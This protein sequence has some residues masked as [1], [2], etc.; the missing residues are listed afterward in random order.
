MT[1][2]ESI[3]DQFAQLVN[4]PEDQIDLVDAALLI[5]RTAYPDMK[6]SHYTGLLDAWGRQLRKQTGPDA[7]TGD[8]LREL[9]RIMFEQEGFKGDSDNYYDPQNSFLNRVLE[10]KK[11]IPITLALVYSEVAR[12]AGFSVYG[13]ALPGHFIVGLFH[14]TGTLYI[15]PFNQGEVLA[16]SECRKMIEV[17][18]GPEAASDASWR[19]PANKK[20]IIKR[21]LRNLKA[22]F[23]HS[24]RDMQILEMIQWIL[25]VDPDAPSELKERGLLYEA[26]GNYAA[27]VLDL[28]HFLEVAPTSEDEQIIKQKV[29][30][31]RSSQQKIH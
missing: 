9:N 27:A 1:H 3:R 23:L 21:M 26:M 8:I 6:R 29:H 30:L 5:A 28:E 2:S 20:K 31:L 18:Y 14:E 25:A 10:R 13:I 4:M 22:I 7:S 17:R 24:G 19:N 15:D 11:G 16:E 12:L